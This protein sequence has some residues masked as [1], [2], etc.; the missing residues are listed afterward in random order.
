MPR[1]RMQVLGVDLNRS[2]SRR[3]GGLPLNDACAGTRFYVFMSGQHGAI[4]MH[5][6]AERACRALRDLRDRGGR[7]FVE[8]VARD[9]RNNGR[10]T[11]GLSVFVP[12]MLGPHVTALRMSEKVIAASSRK[13]RSRL[14]SARRN[15]AC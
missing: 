14:T 1:K 10:G 13:V 6:D 5:L 2:E 15:V 8:P 11:P 12:R 4:V 7:V 3:R 9:Q